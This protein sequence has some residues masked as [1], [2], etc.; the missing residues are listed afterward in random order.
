VVIDEGVQQLD[1]GTL[2]RRVTA[3]VIDIV[4]TLAAVLAF[5]V[6][7]A[8]ATDKGTGIAGPQFPSVGAL[9][10]LGE[11]TACLVVQT[12]VVRS[13][14]GGYTTHIAMPVQPLVPPRGGHACTDRQL[15]IQLRINVPDI[16]TDCIGRT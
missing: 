4:E 8:V 5:E 11:H 13:T 12:A 9:E 10:D 14:C 7:T 16:E 6:I 1:T 2:L 3:G 15:G